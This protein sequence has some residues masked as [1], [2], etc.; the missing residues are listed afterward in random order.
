MARIDMP[1]TAARHHQLR[2]PTATNIWKITLRQ[3][4]TSVVLRERR[5]SPRDPRTGLTV[6]LSRS[7]EI[8]LRRVRG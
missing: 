1:Q 4:A 6:L 2:S 3:R 8:T 7:S 5:T